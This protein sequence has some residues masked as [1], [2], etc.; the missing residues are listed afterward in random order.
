[1]F[2]FYWKYYIP[3]SLQWLSLIVQPTVIKKVDQVVS[4]VRSGNSFCSFFY[5]RDVIK[6]SYKTLITCLTVK[7]QLKIAPD[8][9]VETTAEIVLPSNIWICPSL[10]KVSVGKWLM[11]NDFASLL[12]LILTNSTLYLSASSSIVSSSINALSQARHPRENLFYKN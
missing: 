11:P 10:K 8:N 3:N 6:E 1:M 2:I 5:S 12:S 4:T 9:I 7:K